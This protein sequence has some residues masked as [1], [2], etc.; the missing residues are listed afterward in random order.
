MKDKIILMLADGEKLSPAK[1]RDNLYI[2]NSKNDRFKYDELTKCLKE[3][4]LDGI[5]YYDTYENRYFTFP[6]SFLLLDVD[7]NKKGHMFAS[8]NN[9][10]YDFLPESLPKILPFDRVVAKMHGHQIKV[11][12][13]LKRTN[14]YVICQILPNYKIR[15]V[16]NNNISLDIAKK[17][18][19]NIKVGT[20]ILVKLNEISIHNAITCNFICEVCKSE[21]LAL[22]YNNGFCINYSKEELE[23][24]SSLPKEVDISKLDNYVDHRSD[25]TFTIDDADSY[26]L[27]DAIS[28]NL[29]EDGNISLSVFI[30]DVA[31]YIKP[32]SPLWMRAENLTTSTYCETG[33][34]FHMLHPSISCGICSLNPGALRLAKG[35]IFKISPDGEIL[36][37]KIENSIIKS[38]KKMTYKEVDN[39]LNGLKPMDDYIPFINELFK[40]EQVTKKIA[41]NTLN[42]TTIS[43]KVNEDN[44]LEETRVVKS[45]HPSSDIIATCAVLVGKTLAEHLYNLGSLM[46]YRNHK[47]NYYEE[48]RKLLDGIGY[49]IKA[50]DK[51]EDEYV[52]AKIIDTLKSKEEFLIL[53][54]LIINSSSKAYYDINNIGHY[55]LDTIAYSHATSPIRRFSDLLI[56]TILDNQDVIFNGDFDLEKYKKY[57]KDMA[58]RCTIM[59]KCAEKFTYEYYELQK[60]KGIINNFDKFTIGRITNLNNEYITIK[61]ENDIEGIIYLKDFADGLYK[62]N[63]SSKYLYHPEDSDILMPG[64]VINIYLKD[65]DLEFRKLYFYGNTLNRNM[66]LQ[67]KK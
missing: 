1:I 8:V 35:F 34:I 4:E 38:N 65:Y 49:K 24:M 6:S 20:R 2:S 28:I 18:I 29:L 41:K 53:S 62:Y 27:D 30:A 33:A 58:D 45:N 54:S 47:N 42:D 51:A 39:I 25:I 19:K 22:A 56:G 66:T 23:Q 57:L 7:V 31:H 11:I 15:M 50:L 12:K 3:L 26:D 13:V 61:L 60:I 40:L 21:E 17:S 55:A 46:V 64:M 16:G 37:F 44:I 63:K 10:T 48:F 36:D 5:I 67:K 59:E 14:P 32:G 52:I 9:K 43:Y